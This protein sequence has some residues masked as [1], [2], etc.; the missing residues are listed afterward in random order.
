M[1]L[2]KKINLLTSIAFVFLTSTA[3]IAEQRSRAM[4]ANTKAKAENQKNLHVAVAQASKA[5]KDAFN[6]G[7]AAG[8]AALYEENAVM[9]VKPFGTYEGREQIRAFWENIINGGYAEVIYTNTVTTMLD[10]NS[11]QI[12]SDWKMNN[13]HGVITNELWV[14]QPDGTALLR[15]DHF[16]IAQPEDN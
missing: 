8:A 3:V 5:W 13:A 10:D 1:K 9:V 15:E 12:A 6:A 14:M 11:A 7:N 16:E 4:S 2:N